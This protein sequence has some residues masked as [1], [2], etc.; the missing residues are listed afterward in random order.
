MI[1]NRSRVSGR[2]RRPFL[3]L[4]RATDRPTD[5]RFLFHRQPHCISLEE[6]ALFMCRGWLRSSS[7]PP[8]R[9]WQSKR[10]G[11]ANNNTAG[12]IRWILFRGF[13]SSAHFSFSSSVRLTCNVLRFTGSSS[14]SPSRR[15]QKPFFLSSHVLLSS[16]RREEE[17]EEEE[18][19]RLQFALQ[20][21]PPVKHACVSYQP[22]II[23]LSGYCQ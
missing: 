7:P 14:H 17:E 1:N 20:L 8:L 12:W 21:A 19:R 15:R 6:G 13:R 18:E 9:I 23:W 5:A 16:P 3:F 22:V 10:T 4:P 2:R 11:P